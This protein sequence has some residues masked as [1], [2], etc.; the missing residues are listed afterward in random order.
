[1][2]GYEPYNISSNLSSS[3]D[4]WAIVG[5]LVAICGGIVIYFTFLN[6][7]NAKNYTG[8]TEKIYNFLSFKKLSLEAILKILYLIAA[9]YITITSFSYISTS[10]IAFILFLLI[11]NVIVRLLFEGA[12]LIIMIYKRINDINDKLNKDKDKKKNIK[13][14]NE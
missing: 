1:M 11:G 10:I 9:I 12:L 6:P 13:N 5:L 14:E 8:I 2:Y 7:N 3:P 4:V